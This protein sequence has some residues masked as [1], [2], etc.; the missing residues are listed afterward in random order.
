MKTLRFLGVV[1]LLAGLAVSPAAASGK[2]YGDG[3]SGSD[4]I[5]ISE[6]LTN[7][8][9]YVGEVVRV[10]GLITGVCKKRG[11][12]MSIAADEEEFKEIR[13]KVD[14]GVIIFPMEAK[15][16]RAIAEGV[17]TKIELSM[18]QTLRM[19][20]H[21]CEESGKKF[22]PAEVD[23]PMVVYQIKGSGAVIE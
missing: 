14:D 19:A 8:D 1:F 2:T 22:D 13:I 3:V 5:P 23:G 11:C 18:E 7:P 12:W 20:Q 6:L 9:P 21:E 16:H 15:G 10:E 4:T 17:F